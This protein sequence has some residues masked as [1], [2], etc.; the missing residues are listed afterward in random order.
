MSKEMQEGA[1]AF[2]SSS[3]FISS[4]FLMVFQTGWKLGL[5][6]V[7]KTKNQKQLIGLVKLDSN[8]TPGPR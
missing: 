5:L 1:L 8:D 3:I 6:G 2:T 4:Y 7:K